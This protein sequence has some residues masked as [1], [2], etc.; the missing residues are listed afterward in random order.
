MIRTPGLDVSSLQGAI[1]WEKVAAAGHRFVYVRATIGRRDHD[2]DPRFADNVRGAKAAGLLVGAYHFFI[3]GVMSQLQVDNVAKH[4]ELSRTA[5]D[6]PIALDFEWPDPSEWD[7]RGIIP[8]SLAPQALLLVERMRD[9][10]GRYPV[11]YSYPHFLAK[12]PRSGPSWTSLVE[13][14]IRCPLWIASYPWAANP[15]I[16]TPRDEME[17]HLP[18]PW[19]K[20]T[21]WQ[22]CGNGGRVP[23]VP[24]DCDRNLF[25]GSEEDL[26]AFCRGPA[27]IDEE[28]RDTLKSVPS[29]RVVE[30]PIEVSEAETHETAP[31]EQDAFGHLDEPNEG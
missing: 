31:R 28:D 9:K 1:D 22:W 12:L 8:T 5:M 30:R 24:T 23:G 21:V 15:G 29:A 25:N 20:W 19:P 16:R 11:L 26:R 13:L 14:G 17:P 3:P 4:I 10:F 27:P 6:L 18:E 2:E 7:E